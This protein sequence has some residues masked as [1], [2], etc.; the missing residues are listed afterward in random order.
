MGGEDPTGLLTI[1]EQYE[2]REWLREE[3]RSSI[4][5]LP[6]RRQSCRRQS[7]RRQCQWGHREQAILVSGHSECRNIQHFA[8]RWRRL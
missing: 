5:H 6:S 4:Q 8:F 7:R 2:A 3:K 1:D